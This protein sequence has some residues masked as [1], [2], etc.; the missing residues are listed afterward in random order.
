LGFLT[1]LVE[2]A[3]QGSFDQVIHHLFFDQLNGFRQ[4]EYFPTNFLNKTKAKRKLSDERLKIAPAPY[5]QVDLFNNTE[6]LNYYVA[7]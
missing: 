4:S 3:I 7:S 1:P 5:F 6:I 2:N